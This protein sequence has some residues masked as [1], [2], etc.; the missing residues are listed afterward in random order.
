MNNTLF[1]SRLKNFHLFC[2][3]SFVIGYDIY[4][5]FNY[6]LMYK[7]NSGDGEEA[8]FRVS[9]HNFEELCNELGSG[10]RAEFNR[11]GFLNPPFFGTSLN[12][13]PKTL[14]L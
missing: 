4:D 8:S 5:I 13:A 3:R 1:F 14:V 11:K 12:K 6:S 7:R 2:R 9:L 10:E